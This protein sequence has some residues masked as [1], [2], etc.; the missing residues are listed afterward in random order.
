MKLVSAIVRPFKLQEVRA[1]L[2]SHQLYSFTVSEVRGYGGQGIV[3]FYRGATYTEHF[4]PKV[5]I[6]ILAGDNMVPV[7]LEAV[8]HAAWTGK[9]GDGAVYVQD[10]VEAAS[11]DDLFSGNLEADINAA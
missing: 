1:A 2:A 7:V 10:L 8:Q 3:E 11:M 5:K 4:L 6:E 9:P